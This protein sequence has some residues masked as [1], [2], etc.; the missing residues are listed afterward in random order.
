MSPLL[1]KWK[2]L[3]AQGLLCPALVVQV[4]C[5]QGPD[6]TQS[7][8]PIF[9]VQKGSAAAKRLGPMLDIQPD[10]SAVPRSIHQLAHD[11]LNGFELHVGDQIVASKFAFTAFGNLPV[12]LSTSSC[13]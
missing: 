13:R 1:V 10:I 8:E 7:L 5:I 3:S 4:L 12:D 6:P 9:F 11:G 2:A